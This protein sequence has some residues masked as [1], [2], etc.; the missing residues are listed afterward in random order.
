MGFSVSGATAVLFVGLLF[1][2]GIAYPTVQTAGE[3]LSDAVGEREERLLSQQNT[4]IDVASVSYE[5]STSTL[6][7]A[8]DNAGSTTLSV[9]ATD[10]LVDGTYRVDP[11]VSVDG[12]PGRTIW[13]PGERLTYTLTGVETRPDRVRVVTETGVAET[14]TE[15]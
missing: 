11:T 8:V 6:V 13:V 10:L 5:N 7:V 9:N 2:A 12:Q 4:A 1:A 15:V 3:R 14:V